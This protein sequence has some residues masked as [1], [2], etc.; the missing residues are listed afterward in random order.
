MALSS[1]PLDGKP[2]VVELS[3]PSTRA[4]SGEGREVDGVQSGG[5]LRAA[6]KGNDEG[7]KQNSAK[8]STSV[9]VTNCLPDLNK[10]TLRGAI[11]PF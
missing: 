8:E 4:S 7:G 6:G 11:A 1:T 3:A 9:Y 5:A 2:I 10:K